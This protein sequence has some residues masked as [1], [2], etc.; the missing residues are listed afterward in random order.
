MERK[1][2]TPRVIPDTVMKVRGQ[3]LSRSRR[4]NG[5]NNRDQIIDEQSISVAFDDATVAHL[6]HSFGITGSFFAVRRHHNGLTHLLIQLAQE[7][8][9]YPAVFT[10]EIAGR[11]IS[12]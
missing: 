8:E 6:N 11:L 3:C 5:T 1:T 2:P 12:D 10:V 4:I 7:I 9:N